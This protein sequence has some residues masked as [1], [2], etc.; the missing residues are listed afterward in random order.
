MSDRPIAIYKNRTETYTNPSEINV[1][2][3][4][5]E[6]QLNFSFETSESGGN[7][8]KYILS[9]KLNDAKTELTFEITYKNELISGILFI[10]NN[11]NVS[12]FRNITRLL[13]I[14]IDNL[15]EGNYIIAGFNFVF[16]VRLIIK[17]C[18]DLTT[19]KQTQVEVLLQQEQETTPIM[20][21]LNS[22]LSKINSNT[23]VQIYYQTDNLKLNLGEMVSLLKSDHSYPNGLSKKLIG[24]CN[25]LPTTNTTGIDTFY[26]FKPK[27]SKVLKLEGDNLLDQTNKINEQF[28]NITIDR[29]DK[30]CV[31]FRNILAYSTL[32]YIFAGLSNN[33]IFSCTWL[34]SNNYKKFLRNLEN[35]EFSAVVP[36][37]TEPQPGFDFS[38]Y[39]Q[40]YRSCIQHK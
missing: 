2:I 15:N 31:F 40:Y 25:N 12:S 33:S 19:F 37:F 4:F 24:Y 16:T 35:S 21:T 6:I 10:D 18:R 3:Y 8:L 34:C 22:F 28:N 14:H 36:L 7:Q 32:R 26:S 23:E 38:N 17:D 29:V 27:L 20:S 1:N 11:G 39:N 13:D 30:N 5:E 9:L